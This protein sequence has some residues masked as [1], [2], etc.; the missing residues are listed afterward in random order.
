MAGLQL[1]LGCRLSV[2]DDSELA[3]LLEAW[4]QLNPSFPVPEERSNSSSELEGHEGRTS[5]LEA[6]DRVPAGQTENHRR[7][8]AYGDMVTVL[9]VL[10]SSKLYRVKTRALLGDEAATRARTAA[11]GSVGPLHD[12]AVVR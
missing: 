7:S 9:G 11:T 10:T 2:P 8:W 4:M 12:F 6:P 1:Y 3:T 5:S